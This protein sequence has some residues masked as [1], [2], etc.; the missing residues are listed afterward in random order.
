MIF[1]PLLVSESAIFCGSLHFQ[2]DGRVL[3]NSGL[4]KAI[5]LFCIHYLLV[6]LVEVRDLRRI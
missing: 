4:F 2:P 3:S 5:P 6:D 1:A